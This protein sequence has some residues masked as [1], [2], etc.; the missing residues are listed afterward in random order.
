MFEPIASTILLAARL[1]G[2]L[3]IA[4]VFAARAVPTQV[5]MAMLIAFV[6]TLHPWAAAASTGAPVN[7][8]TVLS[9]TVIGLIVGIGAAIFIGAA[10]TAGEWTAVQM[11]LAGATTVNPLSTESSPVM[12]NF[13]AMT[14]MALLLSVDG[15]L[16]MIDAVLATTELIP[17]GGEWTTAG[18]RISVTVLGANLFLTGLRFAAPVIAVLLIVNVGLG[19][20]ARTTP[21]LNLLMVAFPVQI[22]LGLVA[23][24]L[25]LPLLT[26]VFG[27]WPILFEDLLSRT[28]AGLAVVP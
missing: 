16:V 4:P 12:G 6:V 21:Q 20:L 7:V 26:G 2:L 23:L 10:E 15:H 5:R 25:G 1:A 18:A 11:G 24:I 3:L 28:M 22:G 14:A 9:E 8:V 17:L 27:S 13:M 19:I